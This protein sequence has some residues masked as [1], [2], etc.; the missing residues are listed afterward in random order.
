M[1]KI[2]N[3][4]G[5]TPSVRKSFE[6][7][8]LKYVPTIHEHK[9]NYFR[10]ESVSRLLLSCFPLIPM[11]NISPFGPKTLLKILSAYVCVF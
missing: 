7:L 5:S 9:I 1:G 8:N 10:K 11:A 6:H 3:E 2:L 4:Y